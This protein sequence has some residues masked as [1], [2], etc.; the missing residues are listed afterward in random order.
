M[1]KKRTEPRKRILPTKSTTT[2]GGFVGTWVTTKRSFLNNDAGKGIDSY[3]TILPG[4]KVE[5]H[6]KVVDCKVKDNIIRIP[7]GANP[8]NYW[9]CELRPDGMLKISTSNG[10]MSYLC[11]RTLPKP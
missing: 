8:E 3:W 10:M 5:L 1:L 6:G 2:S 11:K 4:N 7:Y 9:L